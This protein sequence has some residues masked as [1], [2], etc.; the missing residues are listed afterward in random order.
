MPI[1]TGMKKKTFSS[2]EGFQSFHWLY[3]SE[4]LF[5]LIA[6]SFLK[7]VTSALPL[8][9]TPV[10]QGHW[11]G[12]VTAGRL[13]GPSSV[14]QQTL[15]QAT[16]IQDIPRTSQRESSAP[17]FTITVKASFFQC[18][19]VLS[20]LQ[21]PREESTLKQTVTHKPLEHLKWSLLCR[22]ALDWFFLVSGVVLCP[23]FQKSYHVKS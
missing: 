18:V 23:D 12:P 9:L 7:Q 22:L 16:E 20:L 11:T 14:P 5:T 13:Q 4:L 10:R 8:P 2:F 19:R 15:T 21:I 3:L 1:I 17:Q 6:L